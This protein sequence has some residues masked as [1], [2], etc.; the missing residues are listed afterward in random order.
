MFDPAF[1]DLFDPTIIAESG[2]SAQIEQLG[3]SITSQVTDI[4]SA[5]SSETGRD[6]FKPTNK[7]SIALSRIG[8]SISDFSEYKTL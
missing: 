4:N 6:L 1:V 2:L 8:K 3:E 5:Y 7:T